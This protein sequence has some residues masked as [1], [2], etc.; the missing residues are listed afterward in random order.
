MQIDFYNSLS[1]EVHIYTAN[2][3]IYNMFYGNFAL[4]GENTRD[5]YNHCNYLQYQQ[6][7]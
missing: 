6:T 4:N 2:L 1:F 5:P 7:E 3:K